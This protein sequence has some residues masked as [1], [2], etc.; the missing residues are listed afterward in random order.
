M[1]N[2]TYG[3]SDGGP[4]VVVRTLTVSE[5]MTWSV[6]VNGHKLDPGIS[7][8]TSKFPATLTSKNW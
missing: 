5:D 6:T 7:L 4:I 8:A 1:M 2:Q 3:S